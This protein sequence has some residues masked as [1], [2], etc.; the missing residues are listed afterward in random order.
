[1]PRATSNLNSTHL[2]H[3]Y[4]PLDSQQQVAQGSTHQPDH[5]LHPVD[6]LPQEYIQRV[7][8]VHQPQPAQTTTSMRVLDPQSIP[9]HLSFTSKGS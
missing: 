6:L 2:A 1:M 5:L 9:A 8:V 4:R 3:D 7:Q